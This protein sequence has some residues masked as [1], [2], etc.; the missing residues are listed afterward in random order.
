M[1]TGLR[2][3]GEHEK[4]VSSNASNYHYEY[5]KIIYSAGGS[6]PWDR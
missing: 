2:K 4:E 6:L 3:T 1:Y 5:N